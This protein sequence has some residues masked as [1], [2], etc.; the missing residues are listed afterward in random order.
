MYLH[1]KIILQGKGTNNKKKVFS[2]FN[3]DRKNCAEFC[4]LVSDFKA[5]ELRLK[6]YTNI[7]TAYHF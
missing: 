7:K 1:K 6:M 5:F 2:I 3:N 4:M